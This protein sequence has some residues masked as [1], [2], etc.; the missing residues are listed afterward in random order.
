M[1]KKVLSKT[2]MLLTL[3]LV[4]GIVGCGS[5][6]AAPSDP[7]PAEE[8][9]ASGTGEATEEYTAEFNG[10]TYEFVPQ[11]MTW[12]EARLE[13]VKR[14]GHLVTVTSQEE[15]DY[16]KGL[17][18]HIHGDDKGGWLGAYSDGAYGGDK[19]DWC[20]VTGEEWNYT[21]WDNGEPSNSRGTE[22][23]AHFWKE[24]TW[25]DVDNEDSRS[26]HY[27]Y[28]CEYDD[29]SDI[30]GG[31]RPEVQ[32]E[33]EEAKED[34]Q[35]E[36][37]KIEDIGKGKYR[38]RSR[39]RR[40]SMTY[41]SNYQAGSDGDCL[42]VYDGDMA[43]LIVRNITDEVMNYQGDVKEYCKKKA[44]EEMKRNFKILYG[45]STGIDGIKREGSDGKNQVCKVSAN[46]WNG[47]ADVKVVTTVSVFDEYKD[48]SVE[49]TVRTGISRY[50]DK[51]SGNHVD[52]CSAGPYH[53][54]K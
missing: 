8:A 19:N 47:K 50:N 39:S 51:T 5:E 2:C 13:C 49:V 34:P 23:F 36:D 18:L 14:G 54:K 37:P 4:I 12:E 1:K 29:L 32:E 10:H 7:G 15:S 38:I 24:M 31:E 48:G 42:F 53:V 40:V 35:E 52:N 28:I 3:S 20:W 45:N 17:Y 43:Y 6:E 11:D 41:P 30:T 33:P 46:I 27:G 22:W 44:E 25:N 9:P 16:L 26:S 21:N